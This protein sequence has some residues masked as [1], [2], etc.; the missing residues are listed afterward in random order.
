MLNSSAKG[1]LQIRAHFTAPN[2]KKA[3]YGT[4]W[5][6]IE[7]TFNDGTFSETPVF[8]PNTWVNNGRYDL[9]FELSESILKS[10]IEN[11]RIHFDENG[12]P[13][14]MT[15]SL[16]KMSEVSPGIISTIGDKVL[17]ISNS[18]ETSCDNL[19]LE[20]QQP[21]MMNYPPV[22]YQDKG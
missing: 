9:G 13:T 19:V 18:G 16:K 21:Y 2:T 10:Q 14:N 4:N 17:G 1:G 15:Y 11:L 6:Y 20:S 12:F 3:V 22:G 7:A 5:L 8:T